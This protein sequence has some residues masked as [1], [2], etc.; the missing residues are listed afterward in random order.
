MKKNL[1]DCTIAES[2]ED[3]QSQLRKFSRHVYNIRRQFQ[4]LRHVKEQLSQGEIII[5]EGFSERVHCSCIFYGPVLLVGNCPFTMGI[6]TQREVEKVHLF[7]RK[8]FKL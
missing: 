2:E 5:Q 3:L 7:I 6:S 4:E 1:V 8:Q